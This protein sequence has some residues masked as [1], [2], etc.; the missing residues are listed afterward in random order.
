M[1]LSIRGYA[2]HRGVDE[3]AVRKA[4]ASGR[5]TKGADGTIDAAAADASWSANTDPARQAVAVKDTSG[6]FAR[7]RTL[8]EALKAKER[9]L[10][11]DEREGRLVNQDAA[12]KLFFEVARQAR[13]AWLGWPAR[14]AADLAS[15]LGVDPHKVQVELDR[16][17]RAHL[18]EQADARFD[19]GKRE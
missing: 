15:T 13:D 4:L 14:I 19:L 5:I 6:E 10:R 3:K 12:K 2:K 11:I 7:A 18:N 8:N 16:L 9:R 17:I 1:G